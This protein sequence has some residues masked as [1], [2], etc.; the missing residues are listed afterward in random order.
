MRFATHLRRL[1]TPAALALLAALVG[2]ASKG[3]V[4][5]NQC[6]AGDWETLGYRDGVNGYRSTRL[7]AHQ[8]A[9][10]EIGIVPDRATYR[11]GWSEGIAEYCRPGR[12]YEVGL[13]GLA[14][15]AVCPD[16]LAGPFSDAYA[17]GRTLFEARRACA[18][19]EDSIAWYE[20]RRVE[21]ESAL[22]RTGTAQLDPFLAPAERVELA[23]AAKRL[24]DERIAI[25]HE[26]PQLHEEL[27][28]R[29]EELAE[30]ERAPASLGH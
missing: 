18:V 28:V 22:V 3:S 5:E 12:G 2:C 10:G 9:C 15:P 6:R 16:E 30:L 1:R 20:A 21:I 17:A 29:R 26:L 27:A 11:V 25:E 24:V 13:R 23:A 4:S 7:L 19:V 14:L 8:D